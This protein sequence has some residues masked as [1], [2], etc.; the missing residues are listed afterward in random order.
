VRADLRASSFLNLASLAGAVITTVSAV[1]FLVFFVRDLA[2]VHANPY[3]GLVTFVAFP[4]L[5]VVGLLLIPIGMV[6]ERRRRA[7]EPGAMWPTIDLRLASTRRIAGIVAGMTLVNVAVVVLATVQ[8]LDFVDSRTFCTGVCHTPMEPEAVAQQR[9]V[10]ASVRCSMCHVGEGPPGFVR[11][12]LGGVRRLA[13]VVTGSYWRPIPAPVLDLPAARSTCL[14]CHNPEKYFGDLVREIRAYADDEAATEQV[15]TLVLRAGGGAWERGGPHGIHWHASPYTRVEYIATDP[16]RETI[17]WVQVTDLKGVREYAAEGVSAEALAAGERRVMD[18]TDCHNRQGHEIAVSV[19]RAVDGALARGLIPRTLPFV[20]R[21]VVAA[22]K[23]A[24]GG[25]EAVERRVAERLTTF[26][27]S[28]SAGDGA[29]GPQIA[30]AIAAAQR[31]YAGN[32]FPLMNVAWG[33]YPIQLGHTDAPGCFRCHDELH[34]SP[35]GTTISQDCE[36]C[37]R[38]P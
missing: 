6:L 4:A 32:V 27:A 26:Y 8:S 22:L 15:T 23:D 1:G 34:T 38:I 21:E 28:Q 7:A 18:C 16:R 33:T 30:E 20:R 2:G 3:F 36:L 11:A 12:K 35:S 24:S 17:P 10:H 31:L 5:F 37:H 9:S 14:R 29:A 13:A 19:E 25:H